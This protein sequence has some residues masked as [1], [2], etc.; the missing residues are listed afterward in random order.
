MSEDKEQDSE[1]AAGRLSAL[2]TLARKP[3]PHT[4]IIHMT[5]NHP[6]G[7]VLAKLLRREPGELMLDVL[8]LHAEEKY[9]LS[10]EEV[11]ALVKAKPGEMFSVKPDP[12]TS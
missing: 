9:Q 10:D 12:Y 3:K 5:T 11:A 1:V 4:Y 7:Y 2:E 6:L 8:E